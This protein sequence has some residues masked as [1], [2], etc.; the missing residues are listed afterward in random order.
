M[1][2]DTEPAAQG[3][4]PMD[5]DISPETAAVIKAVGRI[6][7]PV[8]VR[9]EGH[10]YFLE[11]AGA[12]NLDRRRGLTTEGQGPA[13]YAPPCPL[14]KLGAPSFCDD[15]GLKYPYLAGSMAHGIS[16]VELV[17]S[18]NRAGMLGFFGAAGLLPEE[19]ESALARLDLD[20]GP[21]GFGVNLI[22]SPNEPELE[23]RAVDL[24]LEKGVG[25]IEAS[26]YMY[27]TLPLVRYRVLGI[28]E[29]QSGNI[30]AP[31]RIVAKVSRRE[32][33][34]RFFSP[35]PEKFIR[36]LLA[37][38]EISEQ[39]AALAG[40]IPMAQDL[41]AE[42]DSGGHTDNQ[43]ALSLFPT[44]LALKDH[45]S[46]KYKYTLPL[47]VGAAGGISTPVS[48]LAAFSMGAAYIMTGTVNQ[49]AVESGTSDAV[50]S[51]LAKA[52]QA[53][54]TMAPAADMFEMGVKVQVLKWGT[55]FPM[56]AAKLLELY[57]AWDGIEALP[58]NEK[59]F[60]EKNLFRD[61]LENIWD[62]TRQYFLKRDK[63]QVLRADKDP[64]HRL[65]LV[66]RWYL[67]QASKWAMTGQPDRAVDYQIYCGP[68]IG[69]FNEW[70]KGG[71]LESVPNRRAADIA[72]NILYGAAV[73]NRF[74]ILR[75][76]GVD[77]GAGIDIPPLPPEQIMEHLQ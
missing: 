26:A 60:L 63:N 6:N 29:D 52:G 49:A 33:A 34:S 32:V 39:Q 21:K 50:R 45:F 72:L 46:E 43:P 57:R 64:K 7:Q 40:L 62:G 53:D 30:A 66:F 2:P 58:R 13:A 74:N 51:L 65:A 42:A 14:H 56:R 23:A 59:I 77:L 3:R 38:K 27:L 18:M 20:P 12:F 9:T 28:K 73:L 70:V 11:T 67:G 31:N 41:T 1:L 55:M 10:N 48:A 5:P 68:S 24:F 35:P 69:A 15:Y 47:R 19:I 25:V 36:E 4:R 22:H 44:M 71:F 37:R 54:V 17:Q 61:T 75:W 16:S 76:Q 8:M